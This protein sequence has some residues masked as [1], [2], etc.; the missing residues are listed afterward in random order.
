MSKKQNI[1]QFEKSLDKFEKSLNKVEKSLNKVE[2][3]L[4]KFEKKFLKD[5]TF[6]S[7]ISI[8]LHI[9]ALVI[10]EKCIKAVM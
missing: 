1:T 5:F 8:N 6:A 4:N 7:K 10:I 3:S 2:K 9:F